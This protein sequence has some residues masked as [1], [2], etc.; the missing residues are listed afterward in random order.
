MTNNIN[1]QIE[2]ESNNGTRGNESN[3]GIFKKYNLI[4][5]GMD[6]YPALIY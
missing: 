1:P 6:L 5:E 3:M 2:I 4:S